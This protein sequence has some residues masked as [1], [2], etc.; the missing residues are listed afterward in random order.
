MEEVVDAGLII[1]Q[2]EP[3]A[4]NQQQV[5][6]IGLVVPVLNNFEGCVDLLQ[7]IRTKHTVSIYVMPQYRQQEALAAAWNHGSQRAFAE[8]CTYALVCNDDIMFSP[9]CID[10]MISEFSRLAPEGVAMVTPN[11]I[12]GQMPDKYSILDYYLP[13]TQETSVSDHPNFS[14][15]L[16]HRNFFD[17]MGTFDEKFYPAW[18]EDNDMHYRIHLAGKRAVCS[19]DC[20]SVHVGGVT[21]SKLENPNSAASQQHYVEKWGSLNRTLVEAFTHP[22]NDQTKD[23]RHW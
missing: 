15:F 23:W 20:P 22:Y 17:E 10:N 16:I 7:S 5:T 14:C 21:T 9:E 19:T 11:N 3:Q 13:A 1:R 4:D 8:G 2:K 18:F 12:L 6:R